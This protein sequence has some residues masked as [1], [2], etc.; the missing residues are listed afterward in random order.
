[1]RKFL[2]VMKREYFKVVWAKAFLVTTF[3]A[4]LLMLAFSFL[5]MLMFSIK[6]DAV[7]LAV[8]EQS[9]KIF[10][11]LRDSLSPERRQERLKQQNEDSLKNLNAS[12]EE[13]LKNSAEQMGGSFSLESIS[14]ENRSID[15]IKADLN[16]R[17]ADEKLDAYLIVPSDFEGES[18]RFELSTRNSSDFVSKTVLEDALNE[19]VRSERLAKV[20][21]TE[22]KL[23]EINR[24][25]DFAVSG[26]DKKGN[27]SEGKGNLFYV[28]FAIA[29]LLYI[30]ITIYGS[31][32][33]G[34]VVEE[35]ETRIA[36]ILFSSARP[37]ELMMG[38]LVGVG[39]AGVT[40]VGIWAISAGG[41]ITYLIAMSGSNDLVSLIPDISP[42]FVIYFLIFYLVGFFI[43]ST[44]YALVGSMVTTTQ[45]GGQFVLP[46]VFILMIGLY[47]VFPIVRDPNSTFSVIASLVPFISP[48]TMP[49]RI[50]IESPPFWQIALS[51]AIN[52]LTIF[53]LVWLTA[54]V[55]RVG[56]LMYGKRATIPEVWKWIRQS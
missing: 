56:M 48:I 24:K 30:S 3:L 38:K 52:I 44:I 36:E 4:P 46:T 25:I 14:T 53:G 2:A 13:K 29:F 42:S 31:A 15:S 41:L 23:K 20:N 5:P 28:A 21:I 6:G 40:Q 39:L 54:K 43:Y 34:A 17:I 27:V 26:V 32:V 33:M 49:A 10:G 45:E 22:Q 11:R 19:A 7:R 9:P 18:V 8:V 55:Y 47:S 50:L 51:I 37:F 1:M 35:K 16:Q 12:Q